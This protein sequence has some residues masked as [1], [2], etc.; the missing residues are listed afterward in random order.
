ML[1]HHD[2]GDNWS[3]EKQHGGHHD[4]GHGNMVPLRFLV[5]H[6]GKHRDAQQCYY[7]K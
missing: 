5:N 3:D 7:E 1:K 2:D 4:D 6:D